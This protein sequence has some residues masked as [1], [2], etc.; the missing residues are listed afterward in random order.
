MFQ[1]IKT[2]YSKAVL[3]NKTVDMSGQI[4]Y[5]LCCSRICG[6]FRIVTASKT[7]GLL[8]DSDDLVLYMFGWTLGLVG[9]D[10][11]DQVEKRQ[12]IKGNRDDSFLYMMVVIKD[13]MEKNLKDMRRVFLELFSGYPTGNNTVVLSRCKQRSWKDYLPS[14][15]SDFEFIMATLKK[16]ILFIMLF[17]RDKQRM[18]VRSLFGKDASGCSVSFMGVNSVGRHGTSRSSS[19]LGE[20]TIILADYSDASQMA[21]ISLPLIRSDHG[22]ILHVSVELLTAKTGF[23]YSLFK[24]MIRAPMFFRDKGLQSGSN[25]DK[26]TEPNAARSSSSEL[27]MLDDREMN[28]TQET[29]IHEE[30]SNSHV[31]FDGSSNASENYN[32]HDVDSV[33]SKVSASQSPPT[34]NLH[35]DVAIDSEENHRLRGSLEA[36]ELSITKLKM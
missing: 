32:T 8:R 26:E 2:T 22:T 7:Y 27:E 29:N 28:K 24:M 12:D 30:C 4:L 17:Y 5:K 25:I 11:K 20:A 16:L 15:S 23:S 36:A 34:E 35:K 18:P 14:D 19:N 13:S 21:A 6:G 10:S 31:T 1:S 33:K 9:V 3:V